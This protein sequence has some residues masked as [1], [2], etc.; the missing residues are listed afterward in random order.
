MTNEKEERL[1]ILLAILENGER[2]TKRKVLDYLIENDLINLREK[3]LKIRESVNEKVW[4]NNLAYIRKHLVDEGCLTNSSHGIWEI[5]DKGRSYFYDLGKEAIHEGSFNF[6]NQDSLGLVENYLEKSYGLD[7]IGKTV[8]KLLNSIEIL[9]PNFNGFTDPRFIE[10]EITYKERII[11]DAQEQLS[12]ENLQQLLQQEEYETF[13]EHVLEIG[14]HPDNNL[15][16]HGAP[17]SGDLALLYDENLDYE[18]FTHAFFNLLYDDGSGSERLDTFCDWVDE[19]GF[20]NKWTFVTYFL[21]VTNPEEELF[22]KPTEMKAL[23]EMLG[24]KICGT[25]VPQASFIKQ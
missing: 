17:S 18:S 22:V 24:K 15:L 25:I 14:Q 16:Y 3:D 8:N 10:R 7:L 13:Y 4:R 20:K 12:K 19:E 23:L 6:I 1:L 5:S 2:A 9:M 21:F 11:S